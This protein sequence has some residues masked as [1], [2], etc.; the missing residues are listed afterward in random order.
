[1]VQAKIAHANDLRE[2]IR[3]VLD[4][5]D[6]NGNRVWTQEELAKEIGISTG[7]LSA[8]AGRRA[9]NT[10]SP[11]N[12]TI[13]KIKKFLRHQHAGEA[14]EG[15]SGDDELAPGAPAVEPLPD[16]ALPKVLDF[17][18]DAEVDAS[19]DSERP[20]APTAPVNPA[21]MPFT[22][23]SRQTFR[24]HLEKVMPE[25]PPDWQVN[26]IIA[27]NGKGA[28]VAE[29]YILLGNHINGSLGDQ[30][31]HVFAFL[32]G[33]TAAERAYNATIQYW[34]YNGEDGK[35]TG[36]DGKVL[37]QRGEDSFQA[38]RNLLINGWKKQHATAAVPDGGTTRSDDAPM[39]ESQVT[40][41][42]ALNN[43][44]ISLEGVR[45]DNESINESNNI[46]PETR[47]V[48]DQPPIALDVFEVAPHPASGTSVARSLHLSTDM[49]SAN[50]KVSTCGG[51]LAQDSGIVFSE[52]PSPWS[53]MD[54]GTVSSD[55]ESVPM[56]QQ[57]NVLRQSYD[58]IPR[59]VEPPMRKPWIRIG[60][61]KFFFCSCTI[62][63]C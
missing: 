27:D 3:S 19:R 52:Q 12:S 10:E 48:D 56:L 60:P 61:W 57:G 15:D 54:D 36:P 46:A 17:R 4:K 14:S 21:L 40:S 37:Y 26:H 28:D 35:Y 1:M 31:D 41:D 32:A 25:I 42:L 30:A 38:A 9:Q 63:C 8:F 16:T 59:M 29:N 6:A 33:K 58:A 44:E 18:H 53:P 55:G 20:S 2:E 22:P 5:R 62:D 23:M 7:C 45:E 39:A 43:Y 47:V 50:E 11:H 51:P 13:Q 34:K 24:D 49:N